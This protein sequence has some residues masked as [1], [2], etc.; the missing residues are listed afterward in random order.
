MFN[1]ATC[2]NHKGADWPMG[3]FPQLE[4]QDE[5]KIPQEQAAGFEKLPY[6]S[7]QV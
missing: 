3:F 7:I 6:Q 2:E 1:P 5:F 4:A